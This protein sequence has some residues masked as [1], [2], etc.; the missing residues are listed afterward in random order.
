MAVAQTRE[1]LKNRYER[2][3][4]QQL[5]RAIRRVRFLDVVNGMLGVGAIILGYALVVV[6]L[7][8]WL[9]LPQSVRQVGFVGL[10]IAGGIY[11]W[12]TVVTPLV[13]PVNPYYAAI[14]VEQTIPDAKNSVVNWLDLHDDEIAPTVRSA[15]G[16]RAAEDLRQADLDQ[17]IQNRNLTWHG[18]IVFGLVIALL[19]CLFAFRGD[20]F[21]SLMARAFRPFGSDAVLPSQ[22]RIQVLEPAAGDAIVAPYQAV[23]IRVH[24]DGRIPTPG[25]PD[26]VRLLLRYAPEEPFE[27]RP[28]EPLPD[29]RDE[30]MIVLT[31]KAIRTGFWYKVAGGDGET[32][33]YRVQVRSSPSLIGFDL[34]HTYRPY[35]RWPPRRTENPNIEDYRGTR[36]EIRAIANRQLAEGRM[37]IETEGQTRAVPAAIDRDQPDTL[38]FQI[39]LE[40]D[41]KY[42]IDFVTVGQESYQDLS[43]YTIRVLGDAPPTVELTKPEQLQRPEPESDLALPADG[44]LRLEGVARDDFGITNLTLRMN[45]DGLELK[46]QAYLAPRSYVLETGGFMR[47]IQYKDDIDFLKIEFTNGLKASPRAG[48][49]LE[50][51]LEATDNCDF[52]APQIGK[53][54]KYRV[55]ITPPRVSEEKVPKTKEEMQEREAKRQEL[56]K[57]RQ[58]AAEEKQEHEDRHEQQRKEQSAKDRQEQQERQQAAEESRSDSRQA[59]SHPGSRNDNRETTSEPDRSQAQSNSQG[60]NENNPAQTR[61]PMGES[62]EEK[63]ERIKEELLREQQAQSRSEHRTDPDNAQP[64]NGGKSERPHNDPKADSSE[65]PVE[66]RN[67]QS[68]GSPA[69]QGKSDSPNPQE[70]TAGQGNSQSENS[71]EASPNSDKSNENKGTGGDGAKP[72]DKKDTNSVKPKNGSGAPDAKPSESQKPADKSPGPSNDGQTD[73]KPEKALPNHGMPDNKRSAEGKPTETG[74][75]PQAKPSTEASGDPSAQTRDAGRKEDRQQ[76]NPT[77]GAEKPSAES[78]SS[79]SPNRPDSSSTNEKKGSQPDGKPNATAQKPLDQPDKRGGSSQNDRDAGS[80]SQSPANGQPMSADRPEP[81]KK[82]QQG[83]SGT[84]PLAPSQAEIDRLKDEATR[85]DGEAKGRDEAKKKLE[86]IAKSDPNPANRQA[87]QEALKQCQEC[88][89]GA[90]GQSPASQGQPA[91][92]SSNAGKSE[93]RSRADR[94][95]SQ[96]SDSASSSGARSQTS[97]EASD[98]SKQGGQGKGSESPMSSGNSGDVPQ[99]SGASP[100]PADDGNRGQA[101]EGQGSGDPKTTT[102]KAH[103]EQPGDRPGRPMGGTPDQPNMKPADQARTNPPQEGDNGST[104]SKS[105]RPQEAKSESKDANTAKPAE[106]TS[107]PGM[108]GNQPGI[109]TQDKPGPRNGDSEPLKVTPSER[110][111]EYLRR[112]GNLNLEK[113]DPQKLRELFKKHNLSEEEYKNWL[114]RQ[115]AKDDL[116]RRA[117]GVNDFRAAERKGNVLNSGVR[118][119]EIPSDRDAGKIYSGSTGQA[120]PEY[121]KAAERFAELLSKPPEPKPR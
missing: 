63:L 24:V 76:A 36:V 75:A 41:A 40:K 16:Q 54:R 21:Q 50:Y 30:W 89:G 62:T 95:P 7:D 79:K 39:V 117:G 112:S 12:R 27:V 109:G 88:E 108:A 28:L 35:L 69:S 99:K 64:G 20:Q 51:W 4:E 107:Q 100:K 49:I 59:Q 43:P 34:L 74:G 82:D 61:D 105:G 13:R 10:V 1:H 3:V 22:T 42:R 94:Q 121:R 102:Q 5:Q 86:Q 93:E 56:D 23:R 104:P 90:P 25:R 72:D 53:S 18:L 32:P 84:E 65:K 92:N 114:A 58:R 116:N 11:L 31:P 91:S 6:L 101:A 47:T 46:P 111:E 19:G 60:T 78:S 97:P 33:E 115:S 87:A 45:L 9:Q 73:A 118:R 57:E 103:G 37:I 52:P 85:K 96:P 2:F 38:R 55:R 70:R 29:S 44:M 26:S 113:V 48:Q 80:S 81:G 110:N 66:S 68:G 67:S 17:A 15:L 77:E 71:S 98:R 8:R 14:Q 120:P 83:K 106:Q 119:V